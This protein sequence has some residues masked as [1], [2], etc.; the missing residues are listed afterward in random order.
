MNSYDLS[1]NFWNWAFDNPEKVSPNHSAI[2]FF[3]IEHCNR[4][5]GRSKFG[6]P[7]Q[8]VMDA[9]GI[10]KHSTYIRYFRDLVDWGFFILIQE[11]KNQYSSNIISFTN[12]LP[13][14]GE[15]LDKAIMNHRDRHRDKQ[16]EYN[17]TTKQL[18]NKTT[19]DFNI[20]WDSFHEITG[21]R[22]TDKTPTF[23]YWKKLS[24]EERNLAMQNI[25]AYFDSVREKKYVKK[26]RTY[27]ADKNFNDEFKPARVIVPIDESNVW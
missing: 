25:K 3:A 7:S 5:G 15:A 16:K 26:A 2:Y 10:K 4:L 22:K 21:K 14:K 12:A 24:E 20:F 17:K 9:I 6:F 27:L 13:K 18:N 19:E 1:R 11:A 8:M 23:N